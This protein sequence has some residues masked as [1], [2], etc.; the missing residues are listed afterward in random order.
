MS[1]KGKYINKFFYYLISLHIY[2]KNF[3]EILFCEIN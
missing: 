2:M 1:K 3:L